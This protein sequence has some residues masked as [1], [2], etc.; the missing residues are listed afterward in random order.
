MRKFVSS[1]LQSF[2]KIENAMKTEIK[3]QETPKRFSPKKHCHDWLISK[4]GL[5]LNNLQCKIK[6][7]DGSFLKPV[8]F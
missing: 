1:K 3:L 2:F 7:N 6:Y 4:T 5:F 8:L